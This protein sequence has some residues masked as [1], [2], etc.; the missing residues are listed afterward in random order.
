MNSS[1][2]LYAKINTFSKSPGAAQMLSYAVFLLETVLF[3]AVILQ[4]LDNTPKIILGIIYSVSLISLIAVTIV[5]SSNDPSDTVMVK[6]R[7]GSR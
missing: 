4:K 1:R 6:Y 3:Y 7:N 2:K 5:C